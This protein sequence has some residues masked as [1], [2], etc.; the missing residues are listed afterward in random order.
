MSLRTLAG[1]RQAILHL[2][3]FALAALMLSTNIGRR[4]QEMLITLIYAV[5]QL[6]LTLVYGVI[7]HGYDYAAMGFVI[8][9]MAANAAFALRTPLML[10][11]HTNPSSPCGV[12]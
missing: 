8:L 6:G 12:R 7:A 1:R 10:S 11:P 3:L 2:G 4:H 5:A 9:L